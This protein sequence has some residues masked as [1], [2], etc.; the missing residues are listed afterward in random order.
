MKTNEFNVKAPNNWL[1]W[2]STFNLNDERPVDLENIKSV[3]ATIA[4]F[5]HKQ[6]I[7]VFKTKL[8]KHSNKINIKRLK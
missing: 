4:Q 3:R 7:A 6:K 8:D 5:Y 1:Y 2:L